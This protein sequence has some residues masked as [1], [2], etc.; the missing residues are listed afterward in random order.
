MPNWKTI[1][2]SSVT[3][4]SEVSI[5]RGIFEGDSLSPLLLI[6]AMIPMTRVLESRAVPILLVSVSAVSAISESIGIGM[7]IGKIIPKF[8]D[9]ADT[10]IKKNV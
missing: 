4:L 10:L 9:T 7:G 6:V 2:T 8:A 3:R 5:R 1:L